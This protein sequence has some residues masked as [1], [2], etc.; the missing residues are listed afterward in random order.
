MQARCH[1]WMY[2]T[3]ASNVKQ[4]WEA[5]LH[6]GEGGLEQVCRGMRYTGP[7]A[8]LQVGQQ[9][10]EEGGPDGFPLGAQAQQRQQLLQ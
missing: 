1:T 5:E 9:G 10:V 2:S 8:G 3:G 6:T 7:P 4:A